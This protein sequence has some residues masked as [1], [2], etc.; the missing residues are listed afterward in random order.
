[1]AQHPK[2][3]LCEGHVVGK[4]KDSDGRPA[5]ISCQQKARRK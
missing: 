4:Q 5:H 2:C 3:R 1:V